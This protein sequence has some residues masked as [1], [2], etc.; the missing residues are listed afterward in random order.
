MIAA[1]LLALLPQAEDPVR[2]RMEVSRPGGPMLTE[3]AT[4]YAGEVLAVD[5]VLEL[6][7]ALTPEMLLSRWRLPL[8]LAP[9]ER[10]RG[11]RGGRRPHRIA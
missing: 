9:D 7:P 3:E 4:L 10:G 5:L 1:L 11:A 6:D 8:D 2:W